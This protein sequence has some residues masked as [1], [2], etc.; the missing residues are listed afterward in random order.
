VQG[1]ES[2]FRVETDSGEILARR[3][4][5]AVPA[6]AAGQFLAEATGG[7]SRLFGE[8]PYA[9][10]VVVGLGYGRSQVAHRLDGFGFLA[11]RKQALRILGCLFSSQLFPGRAPR[12]HVLLTAFAGGSTDP[13][14]TTWEDGQIVETVVAELRRALGITGE[15]VYRVLRRWPRAIPQYEMGHGRFVERVE[16]LEKDLP[17]LYI[18]S[19]FI[20][21]VS[22]PD[23]IQRGAQVAERILRDRGSESAGRS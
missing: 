9:P 14:I 21:G 22:V 19:N 6:E 23:C 2:G 4:V 17:G 11:P 5:L 12:G 20:G 16:E 15:P 18:A 3:V 13:E 10:V 7:R 8:V 1:E